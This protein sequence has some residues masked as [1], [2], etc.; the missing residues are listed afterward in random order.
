[1]HH[2]YNVG[3]KGINECSLRIDLEKST[4]MFGTLA[5]PNGANNAL[6][7]VL[8]GLALRY[9]YNWRVTDA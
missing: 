4:E 5:D 3:S 8:Y 1:M 2:H 9:V 6:A 7:Q